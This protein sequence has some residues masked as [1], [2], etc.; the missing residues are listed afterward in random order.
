M[1][2]PIALGT[3][4]LGLCIGLASLGARAEDSKGLLR[5][6]KIGDAWY[7]PSLSDEDLTGRV[8]LVEYWGKN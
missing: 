7:G 8:V 5:S 3:S 6:V 4:V 2:K 1:T